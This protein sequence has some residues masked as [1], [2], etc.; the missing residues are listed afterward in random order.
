MQTN[1]PTQQ[2][3]DCRHCRKA[4][5]KAKKMPGERRN[6][7]L[8]IC[9]SLTGRGTQ[10]IPQVVGTASTISTA[11]RGSIARRGIH[12][13]SASCICACIRHLEPLVQVCSIDSGHSSNL[14]RKR[15]AEVLGANVQLRT[16]Q[17]ERV[18]RRHI[19]NRQ[20]VL[21]S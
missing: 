9:R 16:D 10:N 17:R 7:G 3:L 8:R 1:N 18:N 13:I 5:E 19:H 11:I 12:G 20:G 15:L 4:T 6:R 21:C 2:I 14:H